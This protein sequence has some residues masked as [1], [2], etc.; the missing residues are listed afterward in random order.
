M[1]EIEERL[2]QVRK[3]TGL[4]QE[5]FGAAIGMSRSEVKNLEYGKTTLKDITIPLIC[6]AYNVDEM[7]LRTGVGEM[8]VHRSREE[9]MAAYFGRLMGGN[10]SDIERA[11]ISLMSKATPE[12]W[13]LVTTFARELAAAL[14]A[15][16][17]PD[18]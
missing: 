5:K 10:C 2:I 7:W 3:E 14:E 13:E 9:E 15:K 17:K 8:F 16:E 6:S 18:H 1:R 12:D 4:S 11:I